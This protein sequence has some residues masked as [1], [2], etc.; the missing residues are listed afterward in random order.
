M[1]DTFAK[2]FLGFLFI[3][4]LMGS[5]LLIAVAKHIYDYLKGR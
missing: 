5:P 1:L 3:A 4:L 2:H